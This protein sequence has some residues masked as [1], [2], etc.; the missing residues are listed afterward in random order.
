MSIQKHGD[1]FS[2]LGMLYFNG[3]GVKKVQYSCFGV[4]RLIDCLIGH[5]DIHVIPKDL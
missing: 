3:M 1:G 4:P 5:S 2:G